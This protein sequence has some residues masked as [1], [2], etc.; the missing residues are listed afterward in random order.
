MPYKNLE[1]RKERAKERYHEGYR[2]TM[3][4][5]QRLY[6]QT[7][8]GK[9]SYLKAR[10]KSRNIEMLLTEDEYSNIITEAVCVYCNGELPP[11]SYGLD[12]KDNNVG[13]TIE[14]VVP[15]CKDCNTFKSDKFT[16]EEWKAA[17]A[18]ILKLRGL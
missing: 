18:A 12:R 10:S 15:C 16:H 7:T 8:K 17:L 11:S 1:R 2:D 14:N 9:Y 3:L 5:K 4:E 6:R 13:Y